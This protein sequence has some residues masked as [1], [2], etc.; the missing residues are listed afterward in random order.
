[1]RKVAIGPKQHEEKVPRKFP[2]WPFSSW[3]SAL[4]CLQVRLVTFLHTV[5]HHVL[6]ESLG[7]LTNL[8]PSTSDFLRVAVTTVRSFHLCKN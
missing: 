5:W 3:V 2:E 7:L 4:A 8:F 6:L 1:M